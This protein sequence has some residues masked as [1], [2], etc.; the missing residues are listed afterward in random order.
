MYSGSGAAWRYRDDRTDSGTSVEIELHSA[1]SSAKSAAPVGALESCA[2]CVSS[3]HEALDVEGDYASRQQTAKR[4]PT[5]TALSRG[6]GTHPRLCLLSAAGGALG[7]RRARAVPGAPRRDARDGGGAEAGDVGIDA[8]PLSRVRSRHG[9]HCRRGA[10][11]R[12]GMP[13]AAACARRGWATASGGRP[14]QGRR[15]AAA[16]GAAVGCS[17]LRSSALR[18]PGSSDAEGCVWARRWW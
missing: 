13:G 6:Q 14:R 2:P 10:A 5:P 3:L 18:R 16:R 12:R 4:V 17:R 11:T 8:R 9:G 1:S 15:G 7:R